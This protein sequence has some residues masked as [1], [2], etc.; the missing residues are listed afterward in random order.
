M[1]DT[2]KSPAAGAAV[3]ELPRDDVRAHRPG[4]LRSSTRR[5]HLRLA[6][7][8]I[9]PA[10]LLYIVFMLAPFFSVIY[11]SFTSWD[12]SAPV[13]EW[14]GL[15]N[16][17]RMIED[18]GF[19]EALWHN[20]IWIVIG[21]IAPIVIGLVLSILLWSRVRGVLFWRT[22]FFLPQILPLVVIAIVWSWL[23]H[24]LY[25]PF[26]KALER[27]G[28]EDWARGWLGE[29][30]W[31]LYAVLLAAIWGTFGFVVVILLA[32]LQNIDES[33][34]DAASVDGANWL[35]RTRHVIVPQLAPLL[36]MVTTITLIGGIQVVDFVFVMT[37]GGPGTASEV[38]ATYAYKIGFTQN[39]VGYGSALSVVITALSLIVAV[40]FLRIRERGQ[41]VG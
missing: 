6:A 16:Y 18:S 39:D 7:L 8:F 23:Y 3:A 12:G 29:P 15:E 38:M 10:L 36:T 4:G 28:R 34:I 32:G 21:T 35:Q 25:G 37:L 30:S 41:T 5:E 1:V 9:A 33:L 26:N 2:A 19:R 20:V 24:P 13:K 40:I 27:V 22:V 31:A 14:V 17:S 11:Y